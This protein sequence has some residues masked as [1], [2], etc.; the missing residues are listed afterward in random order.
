MATNNLTVNAALDAVAKKKG[1]T[2]EEALMLVVAKGLDGVT[3][4]QAYAQGNAIAFGAGGA[5]GK[6]PTAHEL[7]HVIQQKTVQIKNR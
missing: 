2:R 7:V 1:I 5:A 4:A 6:N 3:G